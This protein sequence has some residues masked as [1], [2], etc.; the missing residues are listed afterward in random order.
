MIHRGAQ[1]LLMDNGS[2]KADATRQLRAVAQALGQSAGQPVEAVSLRHA[3]RIDR[4][5]LDGVAALT[6]LPFL[7]QALSCGQRSFVI[8]PLFFA[9]S[10]ALTEYLPRQLQQLYQQYGEFELTMA[11]VLYPLPQ[12][13]PL[14]PALMLQQIRRLHPP[15]TADER[16]V[17]V[18]HGSPDP[19]VT[20]VRQQLAQ[21]LLQQLDEGFI[22]DQAVMERRSGAEYD[23]N[24]ALL[25]QRLHQYARQDVQQVTLLLQF[26]LPGR[27]AGAGGDIEQ[28]RLAV[29]QRYPAL[30]IRQTPL[31]AQHPQLIGILLKRLQAAMQQ[32]SCLARWSG[33]NWHCE[34]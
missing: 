22:L 20:A 31:V 2:I 16:L 28:I 26:L 12:G 10:R 23:F 33:S 27:H 13:E 24:G 1:I 6:L 17:L 32:H 15:L 9:A 4:A 5:E 29:Q 19:Q 21:Q 25:E 14:L 8:V 30:R 18:D 11:D 7:S 34:Q 3:D